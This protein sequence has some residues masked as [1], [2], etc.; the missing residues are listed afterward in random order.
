MLFRHCSWLKPAS[1]TVFQWR[2]WLCCA[3]AGLHRLHSQLSTHSSL[4][5][6]LVHT[7]I[8]ELLAI[9]RNKCTADQPGVSVLPKGTWHA[10]RSSQGSNHRLS[11]WPAPELQDHKPGSSELL[12]ECW[13]Y[14]CTVTVALH[15]GLHCE[16][17][18]TS[19][20]VFE[21]SV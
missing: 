14:S 4:C 18:Q 20:A 15:W 21:H 7:F 5:K 3:N 6:H 19:S 13:Y 16:H 10:D 9:V 11:R 12:A 1:E 17:S 8:Q 2:Y